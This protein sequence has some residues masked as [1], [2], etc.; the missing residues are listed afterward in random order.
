MSDSDLKKGAAESET[1]GERSEVSLAGQLAH[2]PHDSR[3]EGYDTDFPEPGE[4]PEHS[5]QKTG[6]RL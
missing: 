3:I 6:N 5:G 2:R 1:P 4:N